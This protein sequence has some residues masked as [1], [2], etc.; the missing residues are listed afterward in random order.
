MKIELIVDSIYKV[1]ETVMDLHKI[2]YIGDLRQ[3]APQFPEFPW[4]EFD[5]IVDSNKIRFGGKYEELNDFRDKLAD[6]WLI[7]L[8]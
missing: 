7:S 5:V 6:A 8:Q 2:S 4:Y 1:D 3:Q